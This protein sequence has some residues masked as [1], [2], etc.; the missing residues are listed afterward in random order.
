MLL[1]YVTFD[2]MMF[3]ELKFSQEKEASKSN[4]T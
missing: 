4:L 2:V 3:G 1:S